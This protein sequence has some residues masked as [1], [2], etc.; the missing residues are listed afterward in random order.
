[1]KKVVLFSCLF[2]AIRSVSWG[3]DFYLSAGESYVFNI[4][5]FSFLRPS[6]PTDPS[7]GTIFGITGGDWTVRTELFADSLSDPP[8]FNDTFSHSGPIEASGFGIQ[9]G[10]APWPDLQE[11]VRVTALSGTFILDGMRTDEVVNGG[12][13]STGWIQPVPEPSAMTM[14]AAGFAG[15]LACRAQRRRL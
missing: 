1:M 11:V 5:S 10:F 14:V 9:L 7:D 4:T 3:M 12:Y 6:M 13:Y 8:L 15:L 2:L